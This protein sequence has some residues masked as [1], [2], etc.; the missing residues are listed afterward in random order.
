MPLLVNGL[1]WRFPGL[2][3]L[4]CVESA[5]EQ[6]GVPGA[7]PKSKSGL[8]TKSK[9]GSGRQTAGPK[10]QLAG[11]KKL[12][13]PPG[14]AVVA[15]LQEELVSE[16]LRKSKNEKIRLKLSK[17][18]KQCLPEYLLILRNMCL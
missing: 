6:V 9:S 5:S 12:P 11:V 7:H 8:K 1:G 13:S 18:Q 4:V 17:I 15:S 10:V 16:N 3:P 14:L 2:A